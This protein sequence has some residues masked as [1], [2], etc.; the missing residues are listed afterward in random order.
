MRRT[1]AILALGFLVLLA[2]CG[3]TAVDDAALNESAEYDW[4]TSAAV[5]VTAEGSEY[6]AVYTLDND[7]EVELSLHDELLGR[8]PVSISAVKFRYE[9]GT[10]VN[11]SALN[12]EERDRR[13]V[14]TFPESEGQF[15]YTSRSGSRTLMVPVMTNRSHEIILPEGMRIAMPVFGGAN[16]GGFEKDTRDDRLHL[17]WS[18][19]EA[20]RIEVDYYLERDLILYG[21][22]IALLVLVSGAGVVYYR[23]K[24]RRLE[25]ARRAAGLDVEDEK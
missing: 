7:S 5:T 18:S 24:I 9:N 14:V 4:E 3:G 19:M 25:E 22:L 21:G 8:Q 20:D 12:V 1:L 6:R 2:G 13:T 16:P 17:T 23:A 11:A 10:V 15:A